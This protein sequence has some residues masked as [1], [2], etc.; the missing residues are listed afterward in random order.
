M[1]KYDN[2]F[3]ARFEE[4]QK[5]FDLTGINNSNDLATLEMLINLER[6]IRQMQDRLNEIITTGDP[7]EHSADIKKLSDVIRDYTGIFQQLQ[8]TLAIDRRSRKSDTTSSVQDYI[9]DLLS[10]AKAFY[11]EKITRVY[12]PKCNVMVGRFAPVHEHT[13]YEVTFYC[14]QCNEPVTL[15]R[16]AKDTL[17]DLPEEEQAWRSAHR[18]K[19]TSPQPMSPAGTSRISGIPSMVDLGEGLETRQVTFS[20]GE[21]EE[22]LVEEIGEEFSE[23]VSEEEFSGEINEG[24]TE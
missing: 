14:S 17:A 18:A 24:E 3:K 11:E 21:Q 13:A 8:Q 4:Y 2:F 16:G 12:C 10:A 23:E 22:E 20:D 9:D 15:R 1:Q 5:D 7:L 6:V 19:I